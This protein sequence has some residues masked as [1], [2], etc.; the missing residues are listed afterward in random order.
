MDSHFVVVY[1]ADPASVSSHD[2]VFVF[3][4]PGHGQELWCDRFSASASAF[5]PNM[6]TRW[7]TPVKLD[8]Y[9]EPLEIDRLA[10]DE[11]FIPNLEI[12]IVAGK[13]FPEN[14]R[15]EKEKFVILNER[16]VGSFG[17][18][19]ASDALGA[20][21]EFDEG[22]RLEVIGVFIVSLGI[23][24]LL[25]FVIVFSQT[26]RAAYRNPVESLRYE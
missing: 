5:I 22:I 2:L 13:N 17:F 14:S 8:E 4:E 3:P 24:F 25:G 15:L 11:S 16:A 10:V 12:Q 19:S 1:M 9:D 6:G 26:I 21:L 23:M 18:N 20:V 7:P